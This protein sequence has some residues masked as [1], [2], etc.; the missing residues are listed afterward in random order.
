MIERFILLDSDGE[1]DY[2]YD[3]EITEYGYFQTVYKDG[4]FWY[5]GEIS[6]RNY[7]SALSQYMRNDDEYYFVFRDKVWKAL[8]DCNYEYLHELQ[9][10]EPELYYMVMEELNRIQHTN[11][12]NV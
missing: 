5:A 2:K 4:E 3:Y 7:L 10:C 8:D 11:F 9:D 1:S 12:I 6:E